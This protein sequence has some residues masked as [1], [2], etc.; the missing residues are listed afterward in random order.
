M[1]KGKKNS[2]LLLANI[3]YW[4]TKHPPISNCRNIGKP[5]SYDLN[6]KV[7]GRKEI[8]PWSTGSKPNDAE[9]QQNISFFFQNSNAEREG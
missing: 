3:E 2:I 6:L 9:Q 8:L 7:F 4:L 5:I 1:R